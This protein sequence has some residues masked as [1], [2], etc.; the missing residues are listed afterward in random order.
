MKV[1]EELA[2][3]SYKSNQKFQDDLK[4]FTEKVTTSFLKE[5]QQFTCDEI[6]TV[7]YSTGG[8]EFRAHSSL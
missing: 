1:S 4:Q 8:S 6:Q 3:I 5:V 7:I 2:K